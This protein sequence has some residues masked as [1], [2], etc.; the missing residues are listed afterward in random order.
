MCP[1]CSDTPE[2]TAPVQSFEPAH[3]SLLQHSINL[4][5][6]MQHAQQPRAS[7]YTL[8]SAEQHPLR[9]RRCYVEPSCAQ[10]VCSDPV[11]PW[12]SC[13]SLGDAAILPQLQPT[14][15]CGQPA[16]VPANKQIITAAGAGGGKAQ[17]TAIIGGVL[18]GLLGLLLLTALAGG[19]P[20]A[21]D[22]PGVR[23]CR[24]SYGI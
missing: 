15:D 23:G 7:R 4:L 2:S 24:D 18:G 13:M 17:T 19:R 16:L 1:Q 5:H 20:A 11:G 3:A 12:G 8:P 21:P 14:E 6:K 9:M 10:A 22:S